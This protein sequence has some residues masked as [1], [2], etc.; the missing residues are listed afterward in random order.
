[1]Q[2]HI[3]GVTT[4]SAPDAGKQCGCKVPTMVLARPTIFFAAG[5]SC[6]LGTLYGLLWDGVIAGQKDR[7]GKWIINRQ[8][9]ERYR[10]RRNIR[11]AS[12][13]GVIDVAPTQEFR[14]PGIG[15]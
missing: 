9:V 10:I 15:V 1:M 4:P 14:A 6:R 3:A 11:R 7:N 2:I 12:S 5:L 13:H 8:S